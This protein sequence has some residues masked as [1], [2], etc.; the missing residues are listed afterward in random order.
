VDLQKD[1]VVGN[2]VAEALEVAGIVVNKNSVPHDP[3]P[4]FY[5]SGIRLGTPA[6]TTRGMKE[7]EMQ[8]IGKW[9]VE[10]IH[11]VSHYK[12][13]ETKEERKSF[14]AN[15]KKE[16]QMNATLIAI[17]AQVQQLCTHFPIS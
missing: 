1:G 3:N 5:P 12:L 11:E 2:V 13:P 8:Q 7:K 10:V 16:L 9:I 14:L 15:T 17:R 4:P 6:V